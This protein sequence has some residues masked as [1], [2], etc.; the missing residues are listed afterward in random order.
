MKFSWVITCH[1]LD[2]NKLWWGNFSRS[3]EGANF[4]LVGESP[5]SPPSSE[6]LGEGAIRKLFP[7]LWEISQKTSSFRARRT[8]SLRRNVLNIPSFKQFANRK[9]SSGIQKK[10][11]Q[12]KIMQIKSTLNIKIIY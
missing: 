7:S 8:K 5:P 6:G 11:M 1:L 2:G 12:N 9:G 10:I 3:E 4:R